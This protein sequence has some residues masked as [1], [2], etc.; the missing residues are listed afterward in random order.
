MYYTRTSQSVGLL[1][2][3]IRLPTKTYGFNEYVLLPR[4][5]ALEIRLPAKQSHYEMR[6]STRPRPMRRR[7]AAVVPCPRSR[8]RDSKPTAPHRERQPHVCRAERRL[9]NDDAPIWGQL[10]TLRYTLPWYLPESPAVKVRAQLLQGA[11]RSGS[12]SSAAFSA[13]PAVLLAIGGQP[14]AERLLRRRL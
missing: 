4:R 3:E 12:V 7:C 5:I 11:H 1:G 10:S 14:L 6:L 8:A 13:A 2:L 9:P